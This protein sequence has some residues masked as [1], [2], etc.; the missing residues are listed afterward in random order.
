MKYDT[1]KSLGDSKIK[2][3]SIKVEK[4]RGLTATKLSR[5][6]YAIFILLFFSDDGFYTANELTDRKELLRGLNSDHA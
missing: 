3:L 6:A 5:V 4:S 2:A 1:R